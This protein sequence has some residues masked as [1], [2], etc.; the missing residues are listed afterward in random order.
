MEMAI[1]AMEMETVME[2]E[3]AMEMATEMEMEMEMEME[4]ETETAMAMATSTCV[5]RRS[6]TT[7]ARPAQ[8]RAVARS[9]RLAC[10]MPTACA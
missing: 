10:S 9:T 3:T 2:M 6:T 5:T 7:P 1:Q 8:R 4:T